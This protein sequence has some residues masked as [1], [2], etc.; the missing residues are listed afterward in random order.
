[1]ENTVSMGKPLSVLMV[2]AHEPSLDPR[3]RWEADA[4]AARYGVTVLGFNRE[5]GGSMPELE[6]TGGYRTVRLRRYDCGISAYLWRLMRLLPKP[7]LWFLA[8]LAILLF[9]VL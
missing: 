8:G 9:P 1:M 4:A 5:G 2:C 6:E 7:V 3:I